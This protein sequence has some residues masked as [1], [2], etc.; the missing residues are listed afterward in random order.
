MMLVLMVAM[1][2]AT[3]GPRVDPAA[4]PTPPDGA[5]GLPSRARD[6]DALP[7]FQTPPPGYGEVPFWWWTGDPLDEERLIWQIE[8]LHQKGISG[9]QVNYAHEDSN[10]WPTYAAEPP[11]F[12]EAWW[13]IWGRVAD[14]CRQRGMGIGL[15]TYTLDWTRAD[16]LF[17]RLFYSKPE[18]NAFR[19][20]PLR[21][22]RLEA[23]QST[24][25]AA[26]ADL[27]AARA[28]RVAD[29]RLREGGADLM[30]NVRNG[31][32]AWTAPEGEWELWL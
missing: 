25:V 31:R 24:A 22:Q 2:G 9:V 30:P 7:G 10:G 17:R 32:L 5:A 19:L 6:L 18:L 20:Q 3:G 13:R 23:G 11:L 4:V 27:I 28:Y 8:Q 12:S 15:S 14:A 26:P 1:S 21:R 16:N 29:G